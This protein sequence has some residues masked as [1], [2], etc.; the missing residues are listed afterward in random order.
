MSTIINGRGIVSRE[1]S[2]NK[3]NKPRIDIEDNE[4]PEFSIEKYR[5]T[6]LSDKEEWNNFYN[7]KRVC[8]E[9]IESIIIRKR[10]KG[11]QKKI[12][13]GMKDLSDGP[14]YDPC[15]NHI[16][17]WK[18]HKCI[19]NLIGPQKQ[20]VEF[21]SIYRFKTWIILFNLPCL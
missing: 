7:P 4:L 12:Y 2:T 14:Y 13:T 20:N 9:A 1:E 3:E 5:S 6:L 21:Y 8:L 10:G 19:P 18:S 16:H 17:I 11:P 15:G